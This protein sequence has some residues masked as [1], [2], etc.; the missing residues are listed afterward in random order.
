MRPCVCVCMRALWSVF[1]CF[2][3]IHR[4]KINR[5]VIHGN[6]HKSDIDPFFAKNATS[7]VLLFRRSFA[8]AACKHKNHRLRC[9]RVSVSDFVANLEEFGE[10]TFCT[11]VAHTPPKSE[12]VFPSHFDCA[13][14]CIRECFMVKCK[15]SRRGLH[16]SESATFQPIY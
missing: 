14:V 15:C 3:H 16:P 8:S 5:V 9:V 6:Q 11:S 1:L 4:P 2:A 13:Y 10:A 7:P 12:F